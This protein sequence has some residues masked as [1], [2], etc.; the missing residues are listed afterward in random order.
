MAKID[1]KGLAMN[2]LEGSGSALR[3]CS[4]IQFEVGGTHGLK[5][6]LAGVLYFFEEQDSGLYR[7]TH[8]G[9]AAMTHFQESDECFLRPS[10]C[11]AVRLET[12]KCRNLRVKAILS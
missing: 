10:R 7:V 6:L 2:V 12:I 9:V 4:V 11:L 8:F 1:I 3:L 5:I